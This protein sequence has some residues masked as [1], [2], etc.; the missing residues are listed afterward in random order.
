[1][2]AEE[3]T[4]SHGFFRGIARALKAV[5]GEP[6]ANLTTAG[7]QTFQ[8]PPSNRR[9]RCPVCDKTFCKNYALRRHFYTHTGEKPHECPQCGK[10]FSHRGNMLRHTRSHTGYRPHECLQCGRKFSLRSN[11]LRHARTHAAEKPYECGIC[12]KRFTRKHNVGVHMRL[13]SKG[14]SIECLTKFANSSSARRHQRRVHQG[15]VG[16]DNAAAEG[17]RRNFVWWAEVTSFES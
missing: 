3:R 6:R 5:D 1:M 8:V 15:A 17:A 11:M 7:Q 14:K 2:D 4:G 12:Q 13:H 16:N 10:K 9:C